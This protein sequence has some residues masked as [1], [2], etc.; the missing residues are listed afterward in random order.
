MKQ[1]L[2]IYILFILSVLNVNAQSTI[3]DLNQATYDL[4]SVFNKDKR[5]GCAI[6]VIKDGKK[7]YQN[8]FGLANIENEVKITDSTEFFLASVSKQFTGYGI[9]KLI[10]EGTLDYNASI[11]KYLPNENLLW[12]SIQL[13]NLI[14]Q[15]SGIWDWPY[16]FLAAG[17]SFDDVLNSDGIFQLIKSQSEL[18]YPTSSKF[19]Y[20]S[21]NYMLLGEIIKRNIDIDYYDWMNASVLSPAGMTRT[22]FQKN[23]KDIIRNRANG[24]VLKKNDYERTTNNLS[25]IGTGFMYSTIE[26]LGNWM[27]YQ[28]SHKSKIPTQMLQ[29]G[30][31]NNGD[32]IPYAFGLMKRGKD[33]YWHDG[34]LQGFR[35]ITI[36]N[37]N[38]N[39]AFV[40][41]S[42]SGSNYIVRS[43]FTVASMYINDSIPQQKITDF[44]NKFQ[45][46]PQRKRK[47]ESEQKYTNDFT[48]F[49]GVF[50][51]RE[52]LITYKICQKDSS[53]FAMNSTERV[54]L[55]PKNDKNDSFGSDKFMLGDF[56]FER[57]EKGRVIGFSIN[58]R[59]DNTIKFT[60][61]E[62]E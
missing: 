22:F 6:V 39:S 2:V 49:E 42:N 38:E 14:H 48:E 29:T 45:N 35:A 58:Q 55:K 16:L 9:A 8:C 19:Q 25:P 21:S 17:H 28:L 7:V 24:Y 40:L 13:K 36:L 43:A 31:L 3:E 37:P 53:L 15:T 61:I 20:T 46:E 33:I 47:K 5:P 10:N 57:D 4:Y 23:H 12:E 50:L 11:S 59:R 60:R 30:K 34:Y 41:L 51:N 52:L 56:S 62:E 27:I 18:S 54:L 26:D 44:K 32:D 1:L